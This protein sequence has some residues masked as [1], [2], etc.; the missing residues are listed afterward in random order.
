MAGSIRALPS[1]RSLAIDVGTTSLKIGR[2]V[3]GDLRV[4]SVPSSLNISDLVDAFVRNVRNEQDGPFINAIAV[5]G[6]M[7]GLVTI[8]GGKLQPI[9]PWNDTR[10]AEMIPALSE[11]LGPK[12]VSRTGG[13]LEAGYMGATLAWIR[14]YDPERWQRIERVFLPK[15]ALFYALTDMIVTDPTDAVGT[16]LYNPVRGTWDHETLG[17]LAIPPEWLPDVAPITSELGFLRPELAEKTGI[18]QFTPLLPAGG[19][20]PAAAFG[21]HAVERSE[22]L[23]MLSTG[24]QVIIPTHAWRPD[25]RGRWI[26]WP[27]MAKPVPDRTPPVLA[28]GRLLHCGDVIAKVRAALGTSPIRPSNIT[29]LVVRLDDLAAVEGIDPDAIRACFHAVSGSASDAYLQATIESLAFS[30]K[31]KRLEMIHLTRDFPPIKGI[32]GGLI[33]IPSGAR[34]MGI[35]GGLIK[36]PGVAQVIANAS[37]IPLRV[38]DNPDLSVIGA[39]KLVSKIPIENTMSEVIPNESLTSQYEERFDDWMTLSNDAL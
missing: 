4:D 11:R 37:G 21:S 13:P 19:D 38:L 35:G 7:H 18:G 34:N 5:T 15:D 10:S 39:L 22:G 8:E 29:D 26:M 14:Q 12:Y 16:G 17:I 27:G 32:D 36:M 33:R 23:F 30:L 20:T 9:I 31:R 1:R 2:N 6:Q 25:D 28:I 3:Q 24:A